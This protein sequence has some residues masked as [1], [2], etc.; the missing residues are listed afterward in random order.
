MNSNDHE[1]LFLIAAYGRSYSS[2]ETV[3]CDWEAGKDFQVKGGP[4]C[5]IRDMDVLIDMEYPK[6]IYILYK[7]GS[8]QLY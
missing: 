8:V 5:S 1:N 4:Y 3:L 7:G 6:S 2:K